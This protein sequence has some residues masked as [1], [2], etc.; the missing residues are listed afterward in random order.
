MRFLGLSIFSACPLWVKSRH[1]AVQSSCPVFPRK[2]TITHCRECGIIAILRT[3]P[4]ILADPP[5]SS[6]RSFPRWTKPQLRT[7]S[8]YPPSRQ[9]VSFSAVLA[10]RSAAFYVSSFI[11]FPITLSLAAGASGQSGQRA[12]TCVFGRPCSTRA[13]F[14]AA[15][16]SRNT[17]TG[18]T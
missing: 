5:D 6:N 9:A 16:I 10:G 8:T 17:S 14:S 15:S 11:S 7:P 2:Q 12:S 3:T 13:S 18:S 4:A 1:S